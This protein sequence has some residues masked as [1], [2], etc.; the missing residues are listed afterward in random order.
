VFPPLLTPAI[1]AP[2]TLGTSRLVGY[3]PTGHNPGGLV[4]RRAYRSTVL[5]VYEALGQGGRHRG[6]VERHSE[7]VGQAAERG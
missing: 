7:Q 1:P 5:A 2:P 6:V 3:R 4:C